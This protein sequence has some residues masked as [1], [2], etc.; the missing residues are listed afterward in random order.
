M[1]ASAI[2]MSPI[3]SL[4][5]IP[6]PALAPAI[7]PAAIIATR[8]AAIIA[9]ISMI[10]LLLL[11]LSMI[12]LLLLLLLLVGVAAPQVFWRWRFGLL[13]TKLTYCS[14]GISR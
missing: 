6:M 13:R 10:E 8:P 2:V 11:L 14:G 4:P 3:A 7:G 1:A 5:G 9:I 12:E